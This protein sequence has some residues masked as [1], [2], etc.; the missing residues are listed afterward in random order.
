MPPLIYPILLYLLLYC[1][2]CGP[3]EPTPAAPPDRPNILFILVDDLGAH[4]LGATGSRIYET[5]HVDRIASR[6]TYFTTGYANSAVC[7]PSRAS[8][9]SGHYVTE[10]GVTDWIGALT[11]TD[12]RR[13]N[14]ANKSLPAEYVH[15]L[16]PELTS[17]PEALRPRATA[18]FLPKV[19]PGKCGAAV[20]AYRPWL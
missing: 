17:L 1:T 4:D 20:T 19:A 13:Q 18:P 15:Q 3:S 9:M 16:K 11:G 12:W 8:L 2:G 14:R 6:G 7:S 5:P 10:H